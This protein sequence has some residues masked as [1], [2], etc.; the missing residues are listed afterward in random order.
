MQCE[1]I[2]AIECK[3]CIINSSS[4]LF[5]VRA[6]PNV[7]FLCIN[8]TVSVLTGLNI[9]KYRNLAILVK[10]FKKTSGLIHILK[11]LFFKI[12]FLKMQ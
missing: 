1:C 6:D 8:F 3:A 5:K 10:C 11:R 7:I 9:R 4:M 12:C 2:V